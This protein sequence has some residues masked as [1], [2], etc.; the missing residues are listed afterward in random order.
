VGKNELATRVTR[1]ADFWPIG[2]LLTLGSL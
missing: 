1:F 2:R